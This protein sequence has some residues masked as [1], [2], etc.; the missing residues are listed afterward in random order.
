MSHPYQR[1]ISHEIRE[2][3]VLSLVDFL[4]ENAESHWLL[5]NLVIIGHIAFVDT[6]MEQF[7]RVVATAAVKAIVNMSSLFLACG[8]R[9]WS[10]TAAAARNA[11]RTNLLFFAHLIDGQDHIHHD[12]P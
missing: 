5:D 11:G 4:L 6:A 10:A 1:A 8:H 12:P 9:G 3:P 7:R 2:P